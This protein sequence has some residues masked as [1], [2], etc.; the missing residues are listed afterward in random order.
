MVLLAG[1]LA[2]PFCQERGGLDYRETV[3]GWGVWA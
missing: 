3:G 1:L 2:Y